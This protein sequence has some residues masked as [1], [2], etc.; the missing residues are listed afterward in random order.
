MLE[1]WDSDIVLLKRSWA[2]I[3]LTALVSCGGVDDNG[4]EISAVRIFEPLPGST[5]AVAYFRIENFGDDTRKLL[6]VTSPQFGVVE[7]HETTLDENGVARM[8]HIDEML[9]RPESALVFAAGG[10]H[11][12][13]MNPIAPIVDGTR[14]ELQFEIESGVAYSIIVHAESRHRQ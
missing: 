7:M 8:S 14:I 1:I 11:L 2:G 6:G 12:M 3:L 10:R 5:T 9:I 13:L 4:I